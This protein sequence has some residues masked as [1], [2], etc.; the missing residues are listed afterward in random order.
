ML[1]E[2]IQEKYGAVRLEEMKQEEAQFKA[3]VLDIK[4]HKDL[5]NPYDLAKP[6][7]KPL[8]VLDDRAMLTRLAGKTQKELVLELKKNAGG[9]REAVDLIGVI[10]SG[11]ALQETK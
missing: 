9:V 4:Q 5:K 6:T 11:I 1:E 3:K 7:G 10:E 2:G 8:S